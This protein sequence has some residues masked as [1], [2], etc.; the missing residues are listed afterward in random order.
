MPPFFN[1]DFS[2]L[3][4]NKVLRSECFPEVG[5]GLQKI[6]CKNLKNALLSTPAVFLLSLKMYLSEAGLNS[7][8]DAIFKGSVQVFVCLSGVRRA[9]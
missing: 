2:T 7:I 3:K 5:R 6:I 9:Y 1:L 4:K 8:R